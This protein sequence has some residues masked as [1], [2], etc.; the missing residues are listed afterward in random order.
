MLTIGCSVPKDF[1]WIENYKLIWLALVTWCC[2]FIT[3]GEDKKRWKLITRI[4]NVSMDYPL[5][6]EAD[7]CYLLFFPWHNSEIFKSC[8]IGIFWFSD[9]NF[10]GFLSRKTVG[11]V[12]RTKYFLGDRLIGKV[13][14]NFF[15]FWLRGSDLRLL[16]LLLR[17]YCFHLYLC[18][19]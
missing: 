16:I 9:P 8:N 13:A 4:N 5:G 2:Y 14:N 18:I 15:F 11:R 17:H 12:T 3:P 19:W 1:S 7:V 6:L 10:D